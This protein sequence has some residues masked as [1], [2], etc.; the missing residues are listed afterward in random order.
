MP[1]DTDETKPVLVHINPREWAEFKRLVGSRK[2]SITVRRLIRAE[3]R[4]QRAIA[5]RDNR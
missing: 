3:I 2:A 5:R 1:V 4:L